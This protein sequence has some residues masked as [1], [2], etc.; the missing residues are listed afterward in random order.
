[1]PSHKI[2]YPAHAKAQETFPSHLRQYHQRMHTYRMGDA[3][4][5]LGVSAD[6]V[7]RLVDGGKL[8]AERD[9]TSHRIIPG[10]ALAAYAR[11]VH[12]TK[13]NATGTSARNRLSGIV[14][15]VIL[16]DVSAQ[17]EIQAG[18]FRVVATVSRES[19]E[20]L[21]LEPGVPAV[22]VIKSTNVVVDRP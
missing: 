6:T 15:D 5:L 7:R 11:Q 18:P 19:A 4:A 22:A 20:E 8:T 3:A 2:R 14:T 16:G 9:G 1:M 10:P 21:A 13:P 17:V 12:R